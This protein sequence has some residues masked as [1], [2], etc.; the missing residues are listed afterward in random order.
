MPRRPAAP[1]G[2]QVK[3]EVVANEGQ[4][5]ST[6]A[7]GI[8]TIPAKDAAVDG[9]GDLTAAPTK[10]SAAAVLGSTSHCDPLL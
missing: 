5:L 3:P 10:I 7:A 6:A 8:P 2:L 9:E 1:R 4:G